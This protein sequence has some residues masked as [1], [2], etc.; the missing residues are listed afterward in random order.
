MHLRLPALQSPKQLTIT[1]PLRLLMVFVFLH[2][3]AH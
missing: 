2:D 1:R 3:H